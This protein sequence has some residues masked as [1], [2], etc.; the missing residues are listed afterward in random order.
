MQIFWQMKERT[1]EMCS[2][3][4]ISLNFCLQGI[5]NEH[6]IWIIRKSL[7]SPCGEVRKSV[8]KSC[9]FFYM[10]LR[11]KISSGTCEYP[12]QTWNFF[13]QSAIISDNLIC[14]GT[15]PKRLKD[16]GRKRKK[17]DMI[18]SRTAPRKKQTWGIRLRK[19]AKIFRKNLE[20]TD[21]SYNILHI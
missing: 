3:R 11:W 2:T 18:F 21:S 8:S 9:R 14:M 13:T 7:R 5:S 10:P 19:W 1:D 17:E 4:Y 15:T 16:K 12:K 20:S 6:A